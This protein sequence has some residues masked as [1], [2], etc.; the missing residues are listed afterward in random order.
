MKVFFDGHQHAEQIV[1]NTVYSACNSSKLA[2]HN[3]AVLQMHYK[4]AL[5]S[6]FQALQL[7]RLHFVT[8]KIFTR[9]SNGRGGGFEPPNPT[10][11]TPLSVLTVTWSG[12]GFCISAVTG[13]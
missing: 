9:V 12:C 6:D 1:Y 2:I 8:T 4:I 7:F 10:L 11:R 3:I 13:G 5:Y